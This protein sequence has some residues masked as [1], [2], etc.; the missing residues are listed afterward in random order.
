[1]SSAFERLQKLAEEK[2]LKKKS[3]K[4]HPKAAPAKAETSVDVTS[5]PSADGS[6]LPVAPDKDFT[7]VAN[8]IV[9][10]IPK[11]LFI[12][13]SKQMYD[14]LYTL[15]RGAIKPTRTIRISKSSLMR[16]S[17][18]KSTHTFYN[19]VH[20]L[21]QIGLINITR[22]DGE[23]DGNSYE[24]FLPEETQKNDLVH[25]AQ[26][27]LLVHLAQAVQFLH[28]VPSAETALPALGSNPINTGLS[29]TPK[30]SL[31]TL[32]HDD[33][34]ARVREAFSAMTKRLDAAVKKLTGKGVSKSESEK[35]ETLADLLI[36]EMEAAA[37]RADSISS[38]PAF[39]TE[40]LRRK[41]L[42]G[43]LQ[44]QSVKSAKA[45]IDTVGKP[46]AAG[47]YEKKPL[48]KA[49]RKASLLELQDFADED[50]LQDFKKW[51]T[52]ED[53]AWL[54]KELEKTKATQKD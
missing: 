37:S 51:Y 15:T 52:E 17:G 49:G 18:I 31:K 11:G 2:R 28:Q 6:D 48:D 10:E 45:K 25:L 14:Y 13:K 39:L 12:G 22:I 35:W 20:H 46:N 50:F 40:V 7:K 21:E 3:K 36:L 16:G 27:A 1:M 9:R 30:T 8:S 47:E 54:M 4:P 26:L 53:W 44:N 5:S 38:A 34:D 19:N 41:L 33:D 24:V 42:S 23:K 29:S 43:S 32:N